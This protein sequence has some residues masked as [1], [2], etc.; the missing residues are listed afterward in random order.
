MAN[1][2]DIISA[3]ANM[4]FSYHSRFLNYGKFLP[5]LLSTAPG[6]AV[7]TTIL[8]ANRFNLWG[9][10][11]LF[12]AITAMGIPALTTFIS[13]QNIEQHILLGTI[14]CSVCL[15][16]RAVTYQMITGVIVPSLIG[17]LAA[18]HNL[19]GHIWKKEWVRG[20]CIDKR[21]LIKCR[22]IIIGFGIIQAIAVTW[23]VNKQQSEWFDVREELA[24]RK[25]ERQ[26]DKISNSRIITNVTFY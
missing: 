21:D 6:V 4:N 24:R 23:L 19:V 17:I 1:P 20:I 10:G 12:T 5:I 2:A 13:N 11:K 9:P 18:N 15:E 22:P 16:T 14:P 26:S 8:Q 7:S 3:L 25:A